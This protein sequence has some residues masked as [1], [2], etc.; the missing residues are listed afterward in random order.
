M[1]PATA[2]YQKAGRPD[3]AR[4]RWSVP[5]HPL[6]SME[7]D[8]V[9]NREVVFTFLAWLAAAAMAFGAMLLV[10]LWAYTF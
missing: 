1:R 7:G 5:L 9:S 2:S 3:N 10:L 4:G 6:N 8:P